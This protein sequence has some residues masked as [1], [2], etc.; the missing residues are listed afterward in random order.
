[1]SR[2][3]PS[4][5]DWWYYLLIA[6]VALAFGITLYT[7]YASDSAE[8]VQALPGLVISG[9]IGV[10]LPLWLLFRTGYTLEPTQ[11]RVRSGP[12]SWKV[13]LADI[14]SITPTRNP[15]SSPAL[16]LD[17]LMIEHA[18]GRVMISPADKE[19]FL[20]DLEALRAQSNGAAPA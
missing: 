15:L 19:G 6:G 20:R 8:A 1:M 10:G 2:Y 12:F 14:R 3:Y 4:K 13:P 17:R 9:V 16:S 18:R 11:L 5:V 7:V